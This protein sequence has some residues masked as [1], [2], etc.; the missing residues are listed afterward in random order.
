MTLIDA[1]PLI[2]LLDQG[3]AD[4]NACAEVVLDLR[5]PLVTT[6]PVF[7]EAQHLIAAKLGWLA[8]ER[9]W[10]QVLRDEL[11]LITLERESLQR[12][13][14]LMKKY[15]DVPMDLADATLVAAAESLGVSRIFSLDSDFRVYRLHG[16]KAFDI[17]P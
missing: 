2:A 8:Q 17:V 7:T 15:R 10:H 4:H 14:E 13:Y 16:R 9:L 3:D 6:W 5:A 1:G 12:S 11:R